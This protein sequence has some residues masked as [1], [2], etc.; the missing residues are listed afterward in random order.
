MFWAERSTAKFCGSTC[1]K[2]SSRGAAPVPWWKVEA[3]DPERI[4]VAKNTQFLT[5]LLEDN[6][7]MYDRLM[8]FSN[9]HGVRALNGA[10]AIYI[11]MMNLK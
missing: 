5:S 9:R 8:E 1:R 10:I 7:E 11:D 3:V 6:P 2:A 4:Q